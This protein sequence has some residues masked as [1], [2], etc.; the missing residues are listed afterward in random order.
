MRLVGGGPPLQAETTRLVRARQTGLANPSCGI[1]AE[2]RHL[3][4]VGKINCDINLYDES[5]C[6]SE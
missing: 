5:N 3:E 1:A 2:W 6:L 4:G